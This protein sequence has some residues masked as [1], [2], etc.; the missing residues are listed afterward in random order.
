MRFG[1]DAGAI[2]GR[3]EDSVVLAESLSSGIT[4]TFEAGTVAHPDRVVAAAQTVGARVTVGTRGWDVSS[5]VRPSAHPRKSMS[6]GGR[7]AFSVRGFGRKTSVY[8][9][10]MTP[11][12][13]R[14]ESSR[15]A[16]TGGPLYF[17]SRPGA[18][19]RRLGQVSS[20]KRKRGPASA[21][22][23]WSRMY[24]FDPSRTGVKSQE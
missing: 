8:T 19:R 21:Q 18:F 7:S 1:G 16:L 23:M 13:L 24:S 9:R 20:G 3:D 6:H 12:L 4:T 14:G 17:S 2:L 5:M 22:S 15:P 11:L 10:V